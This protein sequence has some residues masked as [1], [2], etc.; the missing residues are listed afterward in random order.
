MHLYVRVLPVIHKPFN[1]ANIFAPNSA[2]KISWHGYS[3]FSTSESVR[4]IVNKKKVA[5]T[6]IIISHV[7]VRTHTYSAINPQSF[8]NLGYTDGIHTTGTMSSTPTPQSTYLCTKPKAVFSGSIIPSNLDNDSKALR[9]YPRISVDDATVTPLVCV[10]MWVGGVVLL[11]CT[12]VRHEVM[13]ATI[14][15]THTTTRAHTRTRAYC[16]RARALHSCTRTT[17]RAHTRIHSHSCTTHAHKS[18]PHE[19]QE[20]CLP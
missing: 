1:N 11:C 9:T 7:G 13:H 12:T 18:P 2:N 4:D 14:T 16:T 17:T 10:C 5:R 3:R 20:E 6:L 8:Y 19:R 15:H